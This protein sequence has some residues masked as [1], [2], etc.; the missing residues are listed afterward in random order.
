MRRFAAHETRSQVARPTN[1]A[2]GAANGSA[3]PGRPPP[4]DLD[5]GGAGGG[6]VK[7]AGSLALASLGDS[8]A[9]RRDAPPRSYRGRGL[10]FAAPGNAPAPDES[11]ARPRLPTQSRGVAAPQGPWSPVRSA[12]LGAAAKGL[13]PPES[14]PN[15]EESRKNSQRRPARAECTTR[16]PRLYGHSGCR[17]IADRRPRVTFSPGSNLIN[18]KAC[19]EITL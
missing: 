16:K 3:R 12:P 7:V 5:H 15:G 14:P 4:L 19:R 2:R 11:P 1:G 13:E 10:P 6:A 9:V 17:A 8:P 18:L